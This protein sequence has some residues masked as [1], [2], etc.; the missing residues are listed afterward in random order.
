MITGKDDRMLEAAPFL[1]DSRLIFLL[2]QLIIDILKLNGF[3]IVACWLLCGV[4]DA[5]GCSDWWA[6]GVE[7]SCDVS[8]D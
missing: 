8:C 2:R 4:S 1:K 6:S 3:G 5:V 7:S